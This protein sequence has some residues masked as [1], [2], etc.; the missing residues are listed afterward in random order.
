[1]LVQELVA[2]LRELG[3]GEVQIL[4]GLAEHVR[5]PLP[6]GLGD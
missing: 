2:R 6:K 5:F 4:D 1:V 3:A